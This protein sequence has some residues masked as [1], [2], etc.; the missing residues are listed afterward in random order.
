MIPTATQRT[1]SLPDSEQQQVQAVERLLHEG[2]PALVN[3]AGERIELPKTVFEVL[4]MAVKFMAD[5]QD[6]HPGS[7]KQGGYNSTC[8]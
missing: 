7:R 1:V 2:V 4:R 6:C 3:G 5:G 8:G